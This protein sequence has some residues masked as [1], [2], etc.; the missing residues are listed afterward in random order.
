MR[1]FAEAR[2]KR[3]YDLAGLGRERPVQDGRADL[4][5]VDDVV[6]EQAVQHLLDR[7]RDCVRPQHREGIG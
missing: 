7:L 2:G 1:T 6:R 3:A 5:G 4:V